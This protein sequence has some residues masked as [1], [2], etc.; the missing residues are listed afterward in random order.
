MV[1][2]PLEG[3]AVGEDALGPAAGHHFGA[4]RLHSGQFGSRHPQYRF[5]P[6]FPPKTTYHVFPVATQ[7]AL[8]PVI[9]NLHLQGLHF[10][11]DGWLDQ[12]HWCTL[13]CKSRW[14]YVWRAMRNNCQILEIGHLWITVET[15][16]TDLF[17]FFKSNL[18]RLLS[19]D[20]NI[21]HLTPCAHGPICIIYGSE[22]KDTMTYF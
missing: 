12:G 1:L 2:I 18:G 22:V 20:T 8:Y 21:R 14:H 5:C 9:D 6:R 7:C 3:R 19:T 16:Q 13:K 4:I 15:N 10:P 11:S 17:Y